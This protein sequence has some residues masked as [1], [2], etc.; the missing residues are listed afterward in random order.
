MLLKYSWSRF[1]SE[2]M[3]KC[4]FSDKPHKEGLDNYS[5]FHAVSVCLKCISF[6]FKH[7]VR[8]TDAF[9]SIYQY[10]FVQM[11]KDLGKVNSK[12]QCQIFSVKMSG[13]QEIKLTNW[14][15]D[16]SDY[17]LLCRENIG[18][19]FI[20]FSQ[21]WSDRGSN[22]WSNAVHLRHTCT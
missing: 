7:L 10:I 4:L 3:E 9:S 13:I 2:L 8:I 12:K 21:V 22:P 20:V 17:F 14:Q 6:N 15:K 16:G 18:T 1:I 19:N 5:R 11:V